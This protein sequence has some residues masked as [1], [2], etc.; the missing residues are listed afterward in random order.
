LPALPLFLKAFFIASNDNGQTFGDP[1][2][3]NATRPAA[4]TNA[5]T[6]TTAGGGVEE[7]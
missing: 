6:T 5:T 7:E 3:L 1:I 2:M 4:G